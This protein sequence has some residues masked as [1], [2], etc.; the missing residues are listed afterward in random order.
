LPLR[1][2][3]RSAR[4]AQSRRIAASQGGPRHGEL[5]LGAFLAHPLLAQWPDRRVELP[6]GLPGQAAG[7]QQPG[8][9]DAYDR[10]PIGTVRDGSVDGGFKGAQ[11]G[12][13]VA[14]EQLAVAAVVGDLGQLEMHPVGGRYLLAAV[15]VGP[16]LPDPAGDVVQHRPIHQ[17]P[18]QHGRLVGTREQRDGFIHERKPVLDPPDQHH[19]QAALLQQHAPVLGRDKVGRLVQ[20][21]EPHVGMALLHLGDGQAEQQ[22]PGERRTRRVGANAGAR[23]G[24][25]AELVRPAEQAQPRP[26]QPCPRHRA[27]RTGLGNAA[28][29][30]L[31]RPGEN[32]VLATGIGH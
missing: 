13:D 1:W 12:R 20:Q 11:R 30:Q 17:R 7:Q 6:G 9:V 27:G 5:G 22:P 14:V 21:V 19:E 25:G 3:L 10:R 26:H 2:N 18:G 32:G 8:Q 24:A 31:P 15:E 28:P 29:V 16:G 23:V 4:R